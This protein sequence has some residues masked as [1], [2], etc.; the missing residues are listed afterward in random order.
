MAAPAFGFGI[1]IH[2]EQW[3]LDLGLGYM[4]EQWLLDLGLG[5]MGEQWLGIGLRVNDH[6]YGLSCYG[7]GLGYV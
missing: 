1:G 7:F 5:Y 6:S 4:G 3:L 2:G